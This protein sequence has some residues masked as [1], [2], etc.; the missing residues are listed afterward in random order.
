M[1]KLDDPVL[2][3]QAKLDAKARELAAAKETVSRLEAEH[4]DAGRD[5][6]AAQEAAD[7][8]LPQCLVVRSKF[9]CGREEEMGRFVI[10]RKT[11]GGVLVTRRVGELSGSEYRFKWDALHS[12]FVQAEK[13]TF[14]GSDTRKARGVPPDFLPV[15]A[16]QAV[17]QQAP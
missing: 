17:G 12:E 8:G 14:Y 13:N 4:A 3:A 15:G 2:V 11:P 1:A 6:R 16:V 9:R 7:A 10:L 5:L